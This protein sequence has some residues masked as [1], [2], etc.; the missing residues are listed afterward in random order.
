MHV[1]C[2]Q[3]LHYVSDIYLLNS[4]LSSEA[5]HLRQATMLSSGF[6]Y[7]PVSQVVFFGVIASSILISITD[8]KPF[9]YI[10][11][12]PLLWKHRQL[13]RLFTWQ[14][15]YVNSTELL[16]AAMTLYHLRIIERLWGSRK[17]AVSQFFSLVL[18]LLSS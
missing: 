12:V 18:H 9:F 17:F 16:F 15:C 1:V 10:S 14:I 3:R 8:S 13:W 5:P 4:S 2:G 7:A 6:T 11:A